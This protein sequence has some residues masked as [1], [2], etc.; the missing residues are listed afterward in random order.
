MLYC[1]NKCCNCGVYTPDVLC[2]SCIQNHRSRRCVKCERY[3]P[4]DMLKTTHSSECNDCLHYC[5]P[6]T[7]N[8]VSNINRYSLGNPIGDQTW[9][10]SVDDV[11]VSSF[12]NHLEKDIT[13]AFEFARNVKEIIRYNFDM[14]VDFY[15]INTGRESEAA[16]A[17]ASRLI[18]QRITS[19]FFT[20]PMTSDLNELNLPDVI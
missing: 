13:I 1:C 9:Y 12:I 14:D 20:S 11:N 16:T 5:R 15:R 10:G 18:V 3:L 8:D 2:N 6:N 4:N 19:R 7:N 17:A